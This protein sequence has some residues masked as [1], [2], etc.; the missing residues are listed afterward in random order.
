MTPKEQLKYE[1]CSKILSGDEDGL[2]ELLIK[3]RNQY[4]KSR[5][6]STGVQVELSED[7]I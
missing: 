3:W 2:E 4:D 6:T 1:I 7:P 5:S